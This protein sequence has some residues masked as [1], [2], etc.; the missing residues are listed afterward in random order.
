VGDRGLQVSVTQTEL[1]ELIADFNDHQLFCRESLSIRNNVGQEIAMELSAGQ[2][3]L[4]EAIQKQRAAKR[5]VRIVALKTR[6][7]QFTSGACSEI[8]HEVA[9]FPGRRA[10]IVADHYKPAAIE[11]FDYLIQFDM[12][13]KPFTRHGE[14]MVKPKLLIP[15]K[16]VSPVSEGVKLEMMWANKAAVDVFSAEAG[17]VGRGGGR[18]WVLFD[19]AA[20]YRD[21]GATLTGALNMIPDEPETAILI[22]STAN[23]VGGEFY[24]ICQKAQD[25][26]NEYGFVFVFFGWLQHGPYKMPV[27]GEPAK[28]Q[29]SLNTEERILVDVHGATLEQLAWRRWKIATTCR[30]EVD[31]FHQ[32]YPTTPEEAFLTSGRPVFDHV[33]LSRHPVYKGRTGELTIIEHG[34]HKQLAFIPREDEKGSLTI[35][36]KPEPGRLYTLA[37]D[38]SK[39]IDVSLSKRGANPDYSVAGVADSLTGE[40]VA[41][42]RARIRPAQFADDIALLGRWYNWAFVNPEVNDAGFFDAFIRTNYP[43]EMIYNRQR[44]PTDR[45][46]AR[47]EELGFYTDE[48]SRKLLVGA[49]E[50]AIRSMSIVIHSSVVI[51]E[52]QT[53]VVKPNG[54][55]EHQTNC[56]DDCV[57]MVGLLEIGRRQ[58]PRRTPASLQPIVRRRYVEVGSK[59]RNPETEE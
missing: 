55:R 13:Y 12:S 33:D 19:E 56:H 30:G 32:E 53:F 11:A 38:P 24:D 52:C 15:K 27:E 28:F 50:D 48:H 1:G 31:L 6:R 58:A 14:S 18:H 22:Q 17:S 29:A 51:N 8:F 49:A 46:P 5:P 10:T 39:G 47:I 37:A 40:M 41:L 3:I 26:S 42:L 35:W 25:P 7:S 2:L 59:R 57:I 9:F 36:R 23:G 54:K 45:R 21:A 34:A 20:W 43:I 44:D 4:D 16:P